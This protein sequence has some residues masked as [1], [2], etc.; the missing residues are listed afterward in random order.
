MTKIQTS[1]PGLRET[2]LLDSEELPIRALRKRLTFS[3][4]WISILIYLITSALALLVSVSSLNVSIDANVH[5]LIAEIQPSV[6][7]ENGELTLR[8][9]AAN[10][11]SED[12]HILHVVQLYDRNGVLREEYGA[13]GLRKLTDGQYQQMGLRFLH[14]FHSQFVPVKDAGYLQIQVDSKQTDEACIHFLFT[15]L[16]LVPV[17][18]LTA[19]GAGYIFCGNAVLP[20][21]QS[22]RVL[23]RFVD[24]AGHEL[25]TPV[26]I[27][28]ASIET[29][30]GALSDDSDNLAIINKVTR[31]SRRLKN[32][33]SHL[34]TLASMESPELRL[35]YAMLDA[36]ALV[37]QVVSDFQ[38]VAEEKQITLTCDVGAGGATM[39]G[40][41]DALQRMLSNLLDNAVRYTPEGGT[42]KVSCTAQNNQ[43]LI[44]VVDSG[45]GIP[46]ESVGHV[47]DR[48]YRVEVARTREQGGTGLGL[49]IVKTIVE[50]HSGSIRLE[51]VLAEGSKFTVVL[52]GRSEAVRFKQVVQAEN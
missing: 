26:A 36:S 35:T 50:A 47:F 30:E 38:S 43:I 29:L 37:R 42:V 24:D 32:L 18:A 11:K 20:V 22:F 21:S 46:P 27:I 14:N 33:S 48:F 52:P 34:V 5:R 23:R 1:A 6:K 41:A 51:S 8:D 28:S 9:W 3:F 15:M 7:I 4:V 44:T 49:S 31:A 19:G 2:R 45:V 16:V 10:A 40:N 17:V 13:P 12:L 25:R 39:S